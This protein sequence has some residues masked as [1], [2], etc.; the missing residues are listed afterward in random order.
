M[1]RRLALFPE[2]TA[3]AA[4]PAGEAL[5]IAACDLHVLADRF[6]TPL[7][8]YDAATLDAALGTYLQA[9]A[10]F[11]P[12]DAGITYAG[13][14]F[15]CT[16]IAQ[17]AARSGLW[18]DCTGEGELAI[19]RAAGVPRAQI[20]VHGV[21][22]SA[23]DLAAAVAHAGTLV[24][25][26]LTELERLA[27]LWRQHQRPFPEL[28]LRFRPGLA[29]DT[30]AYTQTG[31]Q[32]SKFGLEEE[33]LRQAAALCR[34]AGLP[35]TG[36][37][38]HQGSKFRDP[39]PLGAA[40]AR[41]LDLAQAL[42]LGPIWTLSPGG[43]WAVA[44]HE[45]DLPHPPIEVYVQAIARQ[46]RMGCQLRGLTLPHLRLE[47]GRS[48]IARAGVALYRVGAVKHSAGR[49]WLLIDGGLA[50][51]PRPALYG[52]RYSALPVRNPLRPPLGP[53]WLAGPYCESGDVLIEGL[54]LPDINAG[55]LV[56]VP[57]SGAYQLSMSSNYDGARRP[58]VLWLEGGIA[59]SIQVRESLE[60]LIRR[61][62]PLPTTA[63]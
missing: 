23:Q 34:R 33:E 2:T 39:A 10:E 13:K 48:L 47:P 46:V 21:N 32:D 6:G 28:W 42:G 27:D 4:T 12:G 53:A 30:H 11:Y 7:Y 61:D 8:L 38:F 45:D 29:V 37:H 18:V 16:A 40:L 31:Q 51:N 35:L 14:A 44:Y 5:T 25:D 20:L 59:H 63:A 36:L 9:L 15:L 54:A 60:D 52:A 17:W 57:V 55:E 56:A 41:T 62:R 26:N 22:K 58:A 3:L 24:V 19:A 50:D 43:G 1:N 49:R